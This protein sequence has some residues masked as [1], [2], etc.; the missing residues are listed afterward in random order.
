MDLQ[1][2]AIQFQPMDTNRPTGNDSD[3]SQVK[4]STIDTII[5]DMKEQGLVE[6]STSPWAAP[7]VLAKKKD[8]SPR[9]CIDYRRLNDITEYDAYP[10]PD[11]NT[12][13]RQMRGAKV[14]S[15][16]DLKSGYWQTD[17]SEIGVL[18]TSPQPS[19][20][21]NKERRGV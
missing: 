21:A 1:A 5:R 11:L 17:A 19:L 2:N 4:Q 14:Y 8:G 9:L 3:T 12:L 15:V 6:Q 20:F 16:L 7:V 13:I 18:W 10:M